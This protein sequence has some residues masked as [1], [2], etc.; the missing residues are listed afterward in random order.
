MVDITRMVNVQSTTP[1]NFNYTDKLKNPR[2]QKRR[3]EILARDE[4]MCRKCGR[5]DKTLSVHHL[6]YIKGREPWEYSDKYL[7]TYCETC[8]EYANYINYPDIKTW[9]I[10]F[11]NDFYSRV[12]CFLK[13]TLRKLTRKIQVW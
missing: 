5:D 12:I 2:W 4:F 10:I 13:L 3:L 7:I 8:H 9:M 6:K 1:I 11:Q